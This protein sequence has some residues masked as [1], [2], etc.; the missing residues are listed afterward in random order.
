MN[1]RILEIQFFKTK[2]EFNSEYKFDF[3][4]ANYLL[5]EPKIR[6][7]IK[8]FNPK[9]IN[10]MWIIDL[11]NFPELRQY[12]NLLVINTFKQI[13]NTG[14]FID[15]K[16]EKICKLEPFYFISGN[17][18]GFNYN[19]D[20]ITSNETIGDGVIVIPITKQNKECKVKNYLVI[21]D[22]RIKD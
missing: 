1:K 10:D 22:E 15:E 2:D 8:Y 4:S 18:K 16:M 19:G 21:S 17:A 20:L 11:D 3:Y 5:K 6:S 14:I 9:K 7:E 13:D 12:S